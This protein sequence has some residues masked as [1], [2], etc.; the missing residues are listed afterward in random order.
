[1]GELAASIADEVKEPLYSGH[2]NERQRQPTV[3]GCGIAQ[4]SR[5]P[6]CDLPDHSRWKSDWRCDLADAALFKKAP[7][8]KEPVDI[9]EVLQE[10]LILTRTESQKNRV[11][12]RTL[13]AKVFQFT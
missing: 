3:A 6:R 8:A 2:I 13:F 4:P 1:M 12:L 5:S 11:A 7:A 10:L 9:N